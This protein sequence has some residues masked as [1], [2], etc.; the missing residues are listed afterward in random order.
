MK[1]SEAKEVDM[2]YLVLR[3]SP[4][5]SPRLRIGQVMASQIEV[6]PLRSWDRRLI[7]GYCLKPYFDSPHKLLNNS[8]EIKSVFTSS[9]TGS[10]NY[11]Y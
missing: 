10:Y 9:Y 1:K 4:Q 2:N 6:A 11:L 5:L 7:E 3:K 8:T